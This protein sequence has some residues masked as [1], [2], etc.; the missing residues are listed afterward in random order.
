MTV[1][2]PPA[3]EGRWPT[4]TFGM[5]FYT[6]DENLRRF[7]GR[8]ALHGGHGLIHSFNRVSILDQV[9]EAYGA[10]AG[11]DLEQQAR[12]SDRH[13]PPRLVTPLQVPGVPG[14]R[15]TAIVFNPLYLHAQDEAYRRG[16]ISAAY[17]SQQWPATHMTSFVMGYLTSKSDISTHCPITLTGA[18]AYVLSRHA[19]EGVRQTYLRPILKGGDATVTGGTWVT[20][21][22]SGTNAGADSCAAHREDDGTFTLSGQKWF[23]SNASSNLALVLARP[24][25][26]PQGNKGLGLYL[27]PDRIGDRKNPYR[28]TALKDKMGTR[29]LATVELD[30][31]GCTA[32]EIA[33]PP[34]GLRIMMEALQYSRVH[35][36]MSA[37]GVAHRVCL[38]A[39]CWADNRAPFG[40]PLSE[41]PM[42]RKKILG[43]T[44][45]WLASSALA[46]E[47]ARSFCATEERADGDR[48]DSEAWMRMITA[49]AKWRTAESAIQSAK[50]LVEL[51]GGN[52]YT[53]DFQAERLLRDSMVLAVWEGPKEVQ[54]RELARVF[55]KTAG[56]DDII[57]ATLGRVCDELPD[58]VGDLRRAIS[59][60]LRDLQKNLRDLRDNP[61][62]ESE[63]ADDLLHQFADIA[64]L[65]LLAD[66]AAWELATFGDDTKMLAARHFLQKEFGPQH[67]QRPVAG[68]LQAYFAQASAPPAEKAERTEA[69]P[70]SA[71]APALKR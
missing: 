52:G 49:A 46:F 5:N 48:R 47:S 69:R 40:K 7:L 37:A 26:A 44:T 58:S 50:D 53:S 45:E 39:L 43:M 31:N 57:G 19:D 23:A 38:E 56:S 59:R 70:A 51:V 4:H 16:V 6:L 35:N 21:K 68:D 36:A 28:I 3:R 32:I 54:A 22:H 10:W 33:P 34:H 27:V 71:R 55:L 63:V 41:E 64:A 24:D 14:E 65:T 17:R 18:V 15:D 25:D 2:L 30:L 60:E 42:I 20:E 61:A 8:P 12:Y 13:A 62:L 66:E 67:G 1:Q 9:L 11:G 29:G